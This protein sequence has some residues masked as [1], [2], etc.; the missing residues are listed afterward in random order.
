MKTIKHLLILIAVFVCCNL[1][2]QAIQDGETIDINGL[3]V[4]F[5]ITN[6]EKMDLKD[7][8][9]VKYKVTASVTNNGKPISIRLTNYPDANGITA[10][11][12]ISLDCINATGARLT[13]K[14]LELSMK[15]HNI[16]V[17]Y[18]TKDNDGKLVNATMTVTAGYYLDENDKVTGEA[19]FIV[20][21]GEKPKVN[22]R[23]L[24]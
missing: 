24:K 20:P 14:K 22:V 23:S 10:G 8:Q 13:S 19:Q 1:N 18:Y 6:E 17:G 7:G 12:I 9:F 11:K 15:P 5:N 21:A 16:K 3:K 2:A 4:T